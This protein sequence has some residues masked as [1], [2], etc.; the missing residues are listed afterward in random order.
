MK[1]YLIS[2]YFLILLPFA[3][4]SQ[5]DI[6]ELKPNQVKNFGKNAARIGDIYSAI[7]YF[8]RYC[9]L[10]PDNHKFRYKLGELYYKARDYKQAEEQFEKVV[11]SAYEDYPLSLFYYALMQKMNGNYDKAK[12]NF[13]KFKKDYTKAKD[14]KIYRKRATN[15]IAGC[16]IAKELIKNPLKVA[17]THLDTSINK[18]HVEFAP[19]PVNDSTLLYGSLKSEALEYFSVGDSVPALPVRQLY[20]AKKR[21][22]TWSGGEK[23]PGPFNLEQVQTG[24]GVYSADRKRFYFTRCEQTWQ[25]KTICSIYVSNYESGSW[26]EPVKMDERINDPKFTSTQPAVG[27]ESKNNY[28]VLYFV[29]DKPG[30]KGGLDIWY[31]IY[32]A[33]KKTYKNP[34]NGGAKINTV[35]DEMSPFFDRDTKT[36]YFSSNGWPGLGGFDIFKAVGELKNWTVPQNIGYPL[37]SSTDDLYPSVFKD[38]EGGFFVSNREGGIALK[39]A[40]CCDDIYAYRYSKY[41]H[42]ATQGTVF[43]NEDSSAVKY[44]DNNYSG[45]P[46]KVLSTADSTTKAQPKTEEVV[47]TEGKSKPIANASV[48]LYLVDSENNEVLIKIDS[49]DTKGNYFLKLEQGNDYRVVVNSPG[50]F[51]KKLS[52]STKNSTVSD[53]IRT[54]VGIKK[55]PKE[56]IV[57]KNIYYPFDKAVLTDEARISIDTSLLVLLNDN[58]A[59]I[60]E[61][62][63]HTDNKGADD[64]NMR[65]SQKRA[66]SVV[67]YLISKGIDK[68][69]LTAKGYGKTKPI[70]PNANADGTDNPDGR[71]MNRR[72]EFKVIGL[73]EILVSE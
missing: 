70:A 26:T 63:S 54:Q 21:N 37:N 41:I 42:L 36:L 4:F 38:Q 71:Q 48:S 32:D 20:L 69:R 11:K 13:T 22:N 15:E 72:T 62:S 6:S 61:V 18:A 58:P 19:F 5:E 43:E 67:T 46:S 1:K 49:T 34:V 66:E 64:Y 16:D 73:K 30:G 40:T 35:G 44:L 9:E 56:A 25:N 52:I 55:I 23:L 53:T 14:S 60:V 39:S 57:L 45:N 3:G 24:N 28:E 27:F 33:K 7:N 17:I 59:I 51:N 68:S 10:K 29:S 50:F 2:F 65:L 47:F 12:E 31:T 8:K